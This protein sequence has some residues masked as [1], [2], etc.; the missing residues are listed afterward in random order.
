MTKKANSANGGA[1]DELSFEQCLEQLDGIVHQ[2]EDGQLS[3]EQALAAYEAGVRHL[4]RCH[5][6]LEAAERKVELLAGVDAAGNPVTRPL[7]M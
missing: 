7:E 4:K 2:L 1:C 5:G 6:L 3:M